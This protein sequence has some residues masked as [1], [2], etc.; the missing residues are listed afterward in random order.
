MTL[1]PVEHN[2]DAH[3][4]EML[5]ADLSARFINVPADDVD[6]Q[7]EDA[8]RRVCEFLDIDLSLLWQWSV[9]APG[10]LTPTHVYYAP[11]IRPS[12]EPR[13]Q[14]HYPY[15]VQQLLAGRIVGFSS[16]EELPAEASIDLE[17]IR[18]HGIQSNLTIPLEVG[19]ERPIGVLG[20]N[21]LREHRDW[22]DEL[23]TR[24]RLV[25]QIF[26]STLAR[27]HADEALRQSEER[28]SLAADAAGAGL[29]TLDYGT[30]VCWATDR[31]KAIY[32]LAPDEVMTK[33]RLE[34]TVHPD[35]WPFVW[36]A[37]ER[38][39]QGDELVNVDYR[40]VSA[41]GEVRWVV[42]RARPQFT[43][44]GEADRLLGASL[45]ISERKLADEALLASE[46]RLAAAAE[47]AGLA[48][49][50][51]DFAAGTTYIDDRYRDVCG[52]PP[53][54][55]QG[56]QPVD[57]WMEHLHPD[58]RPRVLDARRQLYDGGL[59]PEP[60]SI[61][62]RFLHPTQGEMWI[63]HVACVATRDASG[64]ATR[65]FG[66]LRDVTE[67][68]RAEVELRDLSRR[69]MRA[70]EEERALLA[71][72]LH[73]DLSQRLAVLAIEAGRG[74]LA[75]PDQAQAALR[76]VREGL[77]ELSEDVHS[78]AYQLH[79]SVLKELGLADAL[80]TEGER[81]ARQGLHVWVHLD[82]LPDAITDDA[83]LCLFRVTQEALRNVL[84]HAGAQVATVRLRQADG[85]LLLAVS[86]DGAGFDPG[87][88]D[89]GRHLGLASMRER[90]GL[91]NGTLEIE[92]SVGQGTTL[93]AWVPGEGGS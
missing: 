12:S 31:A 92:S 38:S 6:R 26:A 70:H 43:P 62:Y 23:V 5:V 72:E 35:D 14:E 16:P 30:G 64:H 82:P 45:D 65:T 28:L 75:G 53:E 46:A 55:E 4:F 44:E 84:R 79:P 77:V 39:A 8:L 15:I 59:E 88:P 24:L 54:R 56:L 83:A 21:T 47:L 91:V 81:C 11:G 61:E 50:E 51:V 74:E 22:S 63:R 9:A 49:Y 19:S 37:I 48:F 42:S 33:E 10:D 2:G 29:W 57:S 66:V 73:D 68:K 25:A 17:H 1:R 40:I 69:L 7:I 13:H 78:L 34:A 71:R 52:V 58:D 86:D 18:R 90:L 85:G 41:E 87:S 76:E 80:H 36:G 89:S 3:A 67:H 93:I 20:F 32:G 27:R 60:I